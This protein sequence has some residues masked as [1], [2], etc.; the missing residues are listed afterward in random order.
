MKEVVFWGLGAWELKG[1]HATRCWPRWNWRPGF[2][3]MSET[4]GQV[5]SKKF[6]TNVLQFLH[7]AH[8]HKTAW[9][10]NSYKWPSQLNWTIDQQGWGWNTM[11]FADQELDEYNNQFAIVV[12]WLGNFVQVEWQPNDSVGKQ[13]IFSSQWPRHAWRG[14]WFVSQYNKLK[15]TSHNCTHK[16]KHSLWLAEIQWAE[17]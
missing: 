5:S 12:W 1:M 16:L 14:K 8:A 7:H 4:D 10:L 3:T 11:P 9:K 15:H 6:N 2:F 17:H 13:C